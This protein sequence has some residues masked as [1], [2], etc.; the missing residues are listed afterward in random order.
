MNVSCGEDEGC[1][2]KMRS[3]L[4]WI[5]AMPCPGREQVMKMESL[6]AGG[7]GG[8]QRDHMVVTLVEK[9]T[10]LLN[11]VIGAIARF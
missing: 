6:G 3:R 9:M 4:Y 1:I 10:K 7:D 8:H 5:Q 2:G 11:G